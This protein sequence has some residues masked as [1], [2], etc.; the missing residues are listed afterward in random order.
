[1]QEFDAGGHLLAKWGLRGSA[2]GDF[3]QPA[4]IAVDCAGNVYVADTNNNRVQR[5]GGFA[6]ASAGCIAAAAWPPPL[7]VAPVLSVSLARRAG[8]LAR[9]ALALTVTCQR[10]CRILARATLAPRGRR[11]A[12][13]LIPT[14][15]SLPVALPGHV[16]LRVSAAAL[17]RLRRALGK[18]RALTARITILAV[19]PTGK[20][21][22]VTQTYAVT[23]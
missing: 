9:R 7:D 3:S 11:G 22:V 12:V 14:A 17:R 20:R 10:G 4:A 6:P 21:T 5:F 1:V 23:R 8:V 16:R 19:G 2:L 13:A 15:R 18:T